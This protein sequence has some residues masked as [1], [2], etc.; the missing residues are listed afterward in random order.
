[1][2][3]ALAA[4]GL[5]V[6]L[7]TLSDFG[8]VSLLRYNALTQAIYVQYRSSFDRSLAALL[9]LLLVLA[10]LI[11]LW[12]EQRARGKARTS[13]FNASSSRPPRIVH[14][15]KW[16]WPA[17][18]FA[19]AVVLL[20]VGLPVGVTAT[21][22]VRGLIS[23]Q[24]LPA[25]W[26]ITLNSVI[27]ASLAALLT[28]LAALPIAWLTARYRHPSIPWLER[29]SAIGNGLPGIA[30]ALSLVFFSAN[31]IPFL[32]QTLTLLILA[33]AVRFLP[34]TVGASRA[35]LLHVSPR[36]E[37]AARGLG[38]SPLHTRLRVTLP[39]A[40]PGVL[41]GA[42]LV[43]LT[44]MKELPITLLLGPTGFK[45]LATEIWSATAEAFFARAAAPALLLVLVSS[46]SIGIILSQ[47]RDQ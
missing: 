22:L 1:L 28:V 12:A 25:L 21:W 43:F 9:T 23:G 20:A 7:Y 47:D 10:T 4:G 17:L 41:A 5:L 8:A 26:Q 44:V 37:E 24:A 38:L 39:L 40:R 2:R 15:G 31:Y 33:Y 27:A 42:A 29:G 45:T 3:P 30:I 11:V 46:L 13:R 36:L 32:Y 6:A 19:G 18:L 35:G 14:L 34:Q 16:R